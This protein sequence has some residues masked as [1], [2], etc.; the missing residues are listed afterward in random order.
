MPPSLAAAALAEAIRLKGHTDISLDTIAGLCDVSSGTLM[1]CWKR[2]DE[3]RKQWSQL[4]DILPAENVV[5]K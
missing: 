3:T 2:I 4:C 1:K 5:T